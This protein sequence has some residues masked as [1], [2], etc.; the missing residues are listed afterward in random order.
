MT[1]HTLIR[2]LASEEA[3]LKESVGLI[4]HPLFTAAHE[5]RVAAAEYVDA[6][7][8]FGGLRFVVETDEGY[9]ELG[10]SEAIAAANDRAPVSVE[11]LASGAGGVVTWDGTG[12]NAR[13]TLESVLLALW[14][15]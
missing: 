7:L 10:W 1:N 3:A 14:K 6:V 13:K 15:D 4:G 2:A 5:A 12:R 8:A 9:D 11:H